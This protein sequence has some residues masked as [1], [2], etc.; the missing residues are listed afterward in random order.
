MSRPY[1]TTKS[2]YIVFFKRKGEKNPC[3]STLTI[4]NSDYIIVNAVTAN[5]AFVKAI[6]ISRRNKYMIE[7]ELVAYHIRK[8]KGFPISAYTRCLNH[9]L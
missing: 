3:K 5:E 7:N 6:D 2:Q 8:D 9:M 1:N 4:Y